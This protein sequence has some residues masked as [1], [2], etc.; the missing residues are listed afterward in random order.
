MDGQID[1]ELRSDA[2]MRSQWKDLHGAR[3]L[4]PE[5]RLALA[6]LEEAIGVRQRGPGLRPKTQRAYEEAVDWLAGAASPFTFSFDDVCGFLGIDASYLKA[7]IEAGPAGPI[8]IGQRRA[9]DS[10]MK[11][12]ADRHR[13]RRS[14]PYA[15]KSAEG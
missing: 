9:A 2:V 13:R 6:V 15:S 14:S 7:G 11:I 4:T 10:N 3:H 12:T 8:G 5:Q 1:Q